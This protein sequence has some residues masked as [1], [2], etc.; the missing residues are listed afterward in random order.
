MNYYIG[1]KII[2]TP[3]EVILNQIKSEITNGKLKHIKK[4]DDNDIAVSCPIHKN[5]QEQ[6]PSCMIY[7]KDNDDAVRYGTAH[8]FTCGYKANLAKFVGDCF[9]QDESFGKEWLVE[10]FGTLYNNNYNLLP[11]FEITKSSPKY[12]N[13]S[14]LNQYNYYHPYMWQRKLSKEI[15]DKFEVGYDKASDSITFPIRDEH[16]KLVMITKRNTKSKRFF[17]PKD[18][19]KPVYLLNECI[20]EN[21]DCVYVA[22]SQINALTLWSWGYPAIGLI[23]TGS[24][25]QYNILNK[26]GIRTYILCFDGDEA[27]DKG[28]NRFFKNIR[29]DVL[30]GY[31]NVPKGKDINDLTAEEF[32]ILPVN[33]R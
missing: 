15:V 16:N 4:V 27:G 13:E 26:S 12:I 2:D 18:V 7:C 10:R 20:K 32:S 6:H 25:H 29:D 33:W 23:G 5:G 14:I 21:I 28:R 22:E 19:D 3:I 8:C 24:E 11:E 31:I 30:I 9:D 17:I 1:N